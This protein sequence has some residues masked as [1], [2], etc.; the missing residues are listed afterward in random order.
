MLSF[1]PQNLG[2][3]NYQDMVEFMIL[4]LKT[5][6]IFETPFLL[7]VIVVVL[8]LLNVV[9]GH[10]LKRWHKGIFFSPFVLVAV[11]T[12]STD[13]FTMLCVAAPTTLLLYLSEMVCHGLDKCKGIVIVEK[14]QFNISVDDGK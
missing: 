7:P 8:N 11:V 12:P 4:E 6:L 3:M 1:V 5:T 9:R 13:P 2:I 10:Q 14:G